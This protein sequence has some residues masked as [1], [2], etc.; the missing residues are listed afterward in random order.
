M[1]PGGIAGAAAR[2]FD[3]G[4]GATARRRALARGGC[5]GEVRAAALGFVFNRAGNGLP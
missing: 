2:G 5:F 1:R 4:R 3:A